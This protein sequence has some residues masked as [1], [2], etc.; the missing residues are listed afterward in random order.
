MEQYVDGY[1]LTV[2]QDRLQAYK[3]MATLAGKVWKE[4]GALDYRECVGDDLEKEGMISFRSA[5]GARDGELVIFA[6][7]VF[8][9]RAERDRINAAVMQDPRL[10]ECNP[11][12]VFD[13]KRMS[14]G[15]FRTLVLA[16]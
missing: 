5:A 7:I 13:C 4:H 6:W 3:E 15:G 8:A 1:L 11:E 12:G 9:S 2:P 16:Q 10:T 14:W